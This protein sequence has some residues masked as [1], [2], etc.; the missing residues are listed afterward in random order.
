MSAGVIYNVKVLGYSIGM[1]FSHKE[2]VG[3]AQQATNPQFAKI[4]AVPYFGERHW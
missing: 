1:T 3:W 2:A 4:I